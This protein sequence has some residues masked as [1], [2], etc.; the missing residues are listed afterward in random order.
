MIRVEV[1]RF[2]C[3]KPGC[4]R[5]VFAERLDPAIASAWARRTMRFD[6]VVHQLGLALGGRP[7]QDLA[8]RLAVMVSKDTLLRTI[9]RRAARPA[10]KLRVIGIDDW[11][12]RRGCRY[13]TAI[14][15]QE[16]RRIAA[17]LPD[18]QSQAAAAWLRDD[19]G[20]EIIARD[21]APGYGE[22][23][24]RGAPQAR[25]VADR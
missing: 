7:G 21:R 5:R 6:R 9:R 23:I 2:R 18:R 12:W 14:C 25:Q 22:A 11:A 8:R 24:A 19:P 17:L 3:G 20:I 1:R 16:R 4:L 13:G 15:D 10:T